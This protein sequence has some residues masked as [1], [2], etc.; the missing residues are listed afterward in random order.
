MDADW[1]LPSLRWPNCCCVVELLSYFHTTRLQPYLYLQ[2]A[3]LDGSGQVLLPGGSYLGTRLGYLLLP[4]LPLACHM[5]VSPVPFQDQTTTTFSNSASYFNHHSICLFTSSHFPGKSVLGIIFV[6]M[7]NT[8]RA[9]KTDPSFSPSK[10]F[11]QD[12]LLVQVICCA[13][14]FVLW[15]TPTQK[16]V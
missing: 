1:L 12:L 13:S 10:A 7:L 4:I 11:T 5:L 14:T 15:E 6:L 3:T 8:S 2:Q 9:G 16:L